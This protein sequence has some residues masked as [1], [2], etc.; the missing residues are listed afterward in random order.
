MSLTPQTIAIIIAVLTALS[1][2]LP[3]TKPLWDRLGKAKVI[4]PIAIVV[5]GYALQ[6][7]TS[8]DWLTGLELEVGAIVALLAPGVAEA[9]GKAAVVLCLVLGAF[10]AGGC[11]ALL[12][13]IPPGTTVCVEVTVVGV[14]VRECATNHESAQQ[15]EQKA[16][17]KATRQARARGL[18]R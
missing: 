15:L 3:A 14:T 5:I 16:L 6:G 13:Q 12:D 10:G 7:M 17:A 1:R 18:L 11:A 9:G 2:V 8:G 4:P